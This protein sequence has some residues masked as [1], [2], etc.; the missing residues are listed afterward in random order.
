VAGDGDGIR[1]WL[2]TLVPEYRE[3][4]VGGAET[5]PPDVVDMPG[6]DR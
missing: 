6:W 5:P 3:Q 1:R 4:G 2:R